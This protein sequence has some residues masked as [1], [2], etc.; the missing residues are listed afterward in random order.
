MYGLMMG[1]MFAFYAYC[2]WIGAY[3]IYR[4][5]INPRFDKKYDAGNVLTII[6]GLIIG[7]MVSM[8][9]TPNIQALMKAKV[10]GKKIFDVIDRVPEIKD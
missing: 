7:V 1:F 8:A 5:K 9:I 3:L 2:Y 4:E 10:V 6:M